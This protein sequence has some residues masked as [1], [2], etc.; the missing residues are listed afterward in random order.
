MASSLLLHLLL[1]SDK[2]MGSNFNNWYQKLRIVLEHERILYVI[3]DPA[4][5][6]SALNVD[7]MVRDT[8]QKWL[9][10]YTQYVA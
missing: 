7:V 9:N 10:D 8:Y 4:P 6:V 1:D 5:K 3:M 2:F